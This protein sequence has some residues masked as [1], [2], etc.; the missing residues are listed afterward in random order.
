M[1]NTKSN[2]VTNTTQLPFLIVKLNQGQDSKLYH[3]DCAAQCRI[4]PNC[5][6]L[7]FPE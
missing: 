2:A 3:Q 7:Y 5:L 4:Q 1:C 6:Y